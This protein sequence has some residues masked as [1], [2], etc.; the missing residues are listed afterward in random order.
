MFAQVGRAALL[1]DEGV[2]E[3]IEAGSSMA[4]S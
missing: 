3:E 4:L 1:E 2:V